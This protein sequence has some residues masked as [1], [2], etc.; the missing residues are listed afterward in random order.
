MAP[1]LSWSKALVKKAAKV[2][3][4]TTARSRH[5]TPMATPT[6]FCSAMKHSIYLVA[7][8][9]C[10]N[11]IKTK[12]QR[13]E[14]NNEKINILLLSLYRRRNQYLLGSTFN[15][16]LEKVEFFVSPSSAIMRGHAVASLTRAVP[17]AARVAIFSARR[18]KKLHIQ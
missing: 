13:V 16:A 2:E 14:S 5:A 17:Y 6:R 8:R 11:T 7:E 12:I 4:K 18:E 15:I 10:K 3:Q 9:N 1:I